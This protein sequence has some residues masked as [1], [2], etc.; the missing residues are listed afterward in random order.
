MKFGY[1]RF[2]NF[3]EEV[4]ENVEGRRTDGRRTANLVYTISSPES[5]AQVS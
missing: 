1:N 4:I 2:S 5:S 3:R